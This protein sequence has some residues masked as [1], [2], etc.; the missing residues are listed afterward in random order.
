MLNKE[1]PGSHC[2]GSSFS[3]SG[4]V[5][6]GIAFPYQLVSPDEEG[7]SFPGRNIIP[8]CTSMIIYI[9]L[10]S[11]CMLTCLVKGFDPQKC[12]LLGLT[13]LAQWN[14]QHNHTFLESVSLG[15]DSITTIS[16]REDALGG[17]GS[18]SLPSNDRQTL[19][20]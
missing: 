1:L 16:E 9:K 2:L 7:L 15:C 12:R 10:V 11:C 17:R 4:G 8:Q 20:S 13:S 6:R 19:S 3:L 14:P 5:K 18:L